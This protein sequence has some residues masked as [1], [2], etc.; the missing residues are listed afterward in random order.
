[1][2]FDSS[3]YFF[4]ASLC[5]AFGQLFNEDDDLVNINMKNVLKQSMRFDYSY[6]K[7]VCQ[8]FIDIFDRIYSGKN[9]KYPTVS[10]Y[11]WFGI[12]IYLGFAVSL[13]ILEFFSH[14]NFS[15]NV[16]F[17][18][19]VSG[20]SDTLIMIEL[21]A[22]AVILVYII[23]LKI[24]EYII[25]KFNYLYNRR[26]FFS[27]YRNST[28]N[29]YGESE[30]SKSSLTKCIVMSIC[31]ASLAGASTIIIGTIVKL[32]SPLLVQGGLPYII[33]VSRISEL[34]FF[35]EYEKF[36][37]LNLSGLLWYLLFCLEFFLFFNGYLYIKYSSLVI[38]LGVLISIT[39]FF[40]SAYIYTIL[41]IVDKYKQ[42]FEISPL[43]VILS[44]V[45]FIFI[46][47]LL[48]KELV[49]PFL[50]SYE[51]FDAFLIFLLLNIL[52][53]CLSILETRYML[54]KALSGSIKTLI[55]FLCLDLLASSLIYLIIPILNG[56]LTL[57]LDAIFFNGEMAW[58]GIFYWSSLFT[59]LLFYLCISGFFILHILCKCS[60]NK[61]FVNKPNKWLGII[62]FLIVTTVY[63]ISTKFE[64]VLPIILIIISLILLSLVIMIKSKKLNFNS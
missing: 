44:S 39:V 49:V 20:T 9:A 13:P 2:I 45:F 1:M 59:S 29:S 34:S 58:V 21:W 41:F 60:N 27:N 12:F 22:P 23:G 50:A 55:L 64:F 63:F 33:E 38:L 16:P 11:I 36:D 6:I 46:A 25:P 19:E 40:S 31:L 43:R 17:S 57:F 42:F 56:D 15:V 7:S 48:K 53:D 8:I 14:I 62:I 28:N 52:T 4:I 37:Y 54:N 24:I 51:L 47:S 30:L 10:R 5:I 3:V 18:N 26:F 32:V 35:G 61:Y